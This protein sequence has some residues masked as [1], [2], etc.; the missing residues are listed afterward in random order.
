MRFQHRWPALALFVP[1]AYFS[2]DVRAD[3][4]TI[5]PVWLEKTKTDGR[6]ALARYQ[7]IAEYLDETFDIV[8]SKAPGTE[9]KI[10]FHPRSE[11]Q[12]LIILGDHRMVEIIRRFDDRPTEA[13]GRLE[14][15]NKDYHFV[16]G[17]K[18][19]EG[20]YAIEQYGLGAAKLP[21]KE[22]ELGICKSAYGPLRDA[23]LAIDGKDTFKLRALEWDATRK[24]LRMS[25]DRQ[26]ANTNGNNQFFVDPE[27][28][29]RVVERR[30]ET[31]TLSSQVRYTYGVQVYGLAFP[32]EVK[33]ETRY[34]I[35][36]AP[37]GMNITYRLISV[38]ITDKTPA[39]FR[40]ASFGLPEPVDF[41]QP[42]KATRWYWWLLLA[43]GVC[44]ALALLFSYFRR[45]LRTRAAPA[46]PA[47]TA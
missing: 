34:K 28:S 40:L 17:K 43:G 15:E 19:E 22:Q 21:L 47:A 13:I 16:L 11:R 20:Q 41:I 27:N 32:T 38:K 18:G 9:G 31:H 30:I 5:D 46:I 36:N 35:A 33:S 3:G 10:P 26:I 37:P 4:D 42:K 6:S 12:H 7:L 44:I 25:F 1:L 8:S 39:D 45:R 14:C 24:L 29:W 23:M 2:V